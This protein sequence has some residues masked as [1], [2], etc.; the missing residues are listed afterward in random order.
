M[1]NTGA[2]ELVDERADVRIRRVSR[3]VVQLER[4]AT[5]VSS[6]RSGATETA[7]ADSIS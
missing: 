2:R 1:M 6:A 4:S 7:S 5:D 3:P